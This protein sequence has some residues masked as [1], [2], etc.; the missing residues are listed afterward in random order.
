MQPIGK[1]ILFAGLGIALVGL[2]I[3]LLGDKL[4]WFGH[5]PGDVRVERPNFKLYAPFMSMLLFSIVLSLVL[6]L[7]RRFF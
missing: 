2:I 7:I 3:W 5:L 4:H 6:W 1:L